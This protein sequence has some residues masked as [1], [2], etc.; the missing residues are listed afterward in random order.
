MVYGIAGL[1]V[2]AK[3]LLIVRREEGGVRTYTHLGTGNYNDTTARLY[4]DIGLLTARDAIGR[5]ATL[6]FNA[7]TGYS[8]APR[9]QHLAM[10]PAALKRTL[11]AHIQREAAVA[12]SGGLIMAKMNSLSDPD[13]IAALY[14]ASQAGVTVL[15]NVRGVCLLRPQV[16]GL[17]DTIRVVSVV[18][19]FLEHSRIA[20]FRNGGAEQVYLASAD[21]M[22]R[23]LERRVELM[24]P[25]SSPTCA[26]GWCE[27]WSCTSPTT[28]TPTSCSPTAATASGARQRRN[29]ANA[30]S[31]STPRSACS[32]RPGP[33]S[34]AAYAPTTTSS[35]SAAAHPDS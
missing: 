9:F 29:Q 18:G 20:Y 26:A 35:P 2:H 34:A 10:A 13:V 11:L 27:S 16:P 17:S 23:N 21:W 5:E 28:A 7:V 19:R 30:A 4:T 31:R 24:F 25:S 15:L 3:A 22:P 1:K 32:S 6:F 8:S 14:A 12:D 33:P